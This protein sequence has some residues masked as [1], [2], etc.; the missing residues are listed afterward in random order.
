[1]TYP[2]LVKYSNEGDY[3][4]HFRDKYCKKP[5]KTFDGIPVIFNGMDFD[6][7]FYESS[8]S[9]QPKKDIFS[10]TRAE[11][12]DWIETALLD[13]SAELHCGW[14]SKKKRVDS[15]S[16]VALVNRDYIVVIKILKSGRARFKTA[17]V[18]DNFRTLLKIQ[19]S[20]KW[21]QP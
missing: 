1:M 4:Q 11:R 13:K 9:A 10:T 6:H 15:T 17:F 21:H 7:A 20:P 8:S 3:Q 16:R 2:P 18:A 5:L 12:I 14:D 19:A